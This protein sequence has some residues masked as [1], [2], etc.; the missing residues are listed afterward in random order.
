MI[1]TRYLSQNDRDSGISFVQRARL[2][3]L[4]VNYFK[5]DSSAVARTARAVELAA[6]AAA[7]VVVVHTACCAASHWHR[8]P[9]HERHQAQVIIQGKL[10]AS[11]CPRHPTAGHRLRARS[12]AAALCA[13]T[14]AARARQLDG[15]R[16]QGP[17][18]QGAAGRV[19]G[20]RSQSDRQDRRA[21]CAPRSN[22]RSSRR[23]SNTRSSSRRGTGSCASSSTR[24]SSPSS[25]S[26][27]GRTG[28][29]H[30]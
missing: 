23:G 28:L 27:A 3:R 2:N 12:S 21:P 4:G 7:V 11:A 5:T 9:R 25:S 8:S 26:E 6:A 19:Q 13:R 10:A 14:L 15:R 29:A 17:G 22:T 24:T 18:L 1:W 30:G 20:P 16:L